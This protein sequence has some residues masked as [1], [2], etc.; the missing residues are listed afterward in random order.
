MICSRR[1]SPQK[2]ILRHVFPLKM[3]DIDH[4]DNLAAANLTLKQ[5]VLHQKWKRKKKEQ[6]R[7]EKKPGWLII[8]RTNPLDLI[9]LDLDSEP[10]SYCFCFICFGFL[11]YHHAAMPIHQTV[12]S[13]WR[14]YESR[15][16]L[17][18]EDWIKHISIGT[19]LQQNT[20]YNG[21]I[22]F[23]TYV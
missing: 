1:P 15:H 3:R 9:V 2:K 7:L 23:L 14:S 17:P 16:L 5:A 11:L 6:L 20:T 4:Q 19:L 10:F 13:P 8:G 21:E 12:A 22:W 18:W